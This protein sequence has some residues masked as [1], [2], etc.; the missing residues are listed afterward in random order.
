MM[1]LM[2][3]MVLLENVDD[4]DDGHNDDDHDERF[5]GKSFEAIIDGIILLFV[6]Y[7]NVTIK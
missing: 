2:V 5:I 4:D 3:M 6:F 1:M 7:N